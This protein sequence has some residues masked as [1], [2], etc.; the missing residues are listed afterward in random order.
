MH[1]I[2]VL[3]VDDHR[4]L[5]EA[6]KPLLEEAPGI[7]VKAFAETATEGLCQAKSSDFDVALVDLSL[8]DRDGLW[9]VQR[10]REEAPEVAAV[11]LSMQADEWIVEKAIDSGAAGY[12]SK[13]ARPD[14]IVA[15]I[16]GAA[17][18]RSSRADS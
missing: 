12:V 13:A 17:R 6:L 7:L 9:L 8:P 11:I 5:M 4:P 18:Q 3:I 10:L 1:E 2:R 14:E 16:R 15:A